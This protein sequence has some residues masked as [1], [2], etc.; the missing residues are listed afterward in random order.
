MMNPIVP[1]MEFSGRIYIY[2]RVAQRCFDSCLKSVDVV[3]AL[4]A[5]LFTSVSVCFSEVMHPETA[6]E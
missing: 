1:H 6:T 3:V 2:P 4:A 5:N